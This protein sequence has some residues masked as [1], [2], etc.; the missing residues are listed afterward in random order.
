MSTNIPTQAGFYI[1][2]FTTPEVKA[3]EGFNSV[4]KFYPA[5]FL[6]GLRF[7]QELRA[8][9][10]ISRGKPVAAITVGTGAKQETFLVPAG[11]R[12]ELEEV[13]AGKPA[14]L[15]YTAEDVRK[16]QKNAKGELA[17]VGDSVAQSMIDAGI[18]EVP[19]FCGIANYDYFRH[20]GGDGFTPTTFDRYNFRPQASVSFNM[21]YH[22]EYPI[23]ATV[24][25][26]I[27]A[28]LAGIAC[29]VGE[30]VKAGQFITYD[31]YSNFVTTSTD[32]TY[33]DAQ[34]EAVIGQVTLVHMLRDAQTKEVLPGASVAGL[35][36]VVTPR[37]IA[38]TA[39]NELPGRHNQG[40]PQKI[41]YSNG[42]GLVHI[43]L[44]T[45]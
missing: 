21:D 31:K 45:R 36:H 27:A 2:G 41:T 40:M 11:L 22:Y 33:G 37:N 28:P 10:V 24:E 15:V 18:T 6:P 9:V 7:N 16:G 1:E 44:Q 20:P 12:F 13:K 43:G 35:E 19:F 26:Y 17:K 34:P 39:L 42:I 8:D 4:G 14:T 3:S 30:T 25:D 5:P 38:G 32:F 29:F 23:V